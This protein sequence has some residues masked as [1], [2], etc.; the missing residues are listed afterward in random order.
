MQGAHSRI[1]LMDC[2]T[3]DIHPAQGHNTV[4]AYV[5]VIK[6]N[7]TKMIFTNNR[8]VKLCEA[9]KMNILLKKTQDLNFQ[10]YFS[11]IFIIL[12]GRTPSSFVI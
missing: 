1:A 8:I 2:R 11:F 7:A 5:Y 10:F 4:S 6:F 12:E 3:F 9:E